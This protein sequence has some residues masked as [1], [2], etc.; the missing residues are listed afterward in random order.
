MQQGCRGDKLSVEKVT[1]SLD[2]PAPSALQCGI[3]YRMSAVG[4]RNKV[5]TA[6]FF[7]EWIPA[8]SASV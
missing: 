5:T 1:D 2:L 7:S 6:P 3:S 4:L 8:A